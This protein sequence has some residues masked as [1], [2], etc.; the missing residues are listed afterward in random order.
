[1]TNEMEF[2]KRRIDR[3]EVKNATISECADSLRR[4]GIRICSFENLNMNQSSPLI[5]SDITIAQIL[6]RI[7]EINPGYRWDEPNIGLINIVPNKSVLDSPV[8][9]TVVSSKGAWR[10]LE[11]DLHISALGILLFEEFGDTD[12]PTIDINLQNADLRF[13]LNAIVAQLEPMVWHIFGQPKAYYLSFT[14][15]SM[16]AV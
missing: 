2:L 8:P 12:G 9:D 1:M 11:D 4:L 14:I 3:F 5:F 6:E 15:V 13:A 16:A 10:L 7:I